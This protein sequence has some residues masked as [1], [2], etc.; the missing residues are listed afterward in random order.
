MTNRPANLPR[1]LVA[2]L[3][4]LTMV[5]G[6]APVSALAQDDW[7]QLVITLSWVDA[8]GNSSQ[9]DAQPVT[10][11]TDQSFWAQV[12]AD[13][14]LGALTITAAHPNHGY[15]F[16]I[17]DEDGSLN[18]YDTG[19]EMVTDNR[20]MIRAFEGDALVDIY[21]LY[22]STQIMPQEP[23]FTPAQA[24]VSVIWKD[25]AGNILLQDNP[26][27]TQGA[28]QT[29][30]ANEF[31]GYTF[32]GS[33]A[34]VTVSVDGNGTPSRNPVEFLYRADPKSAQ[35][36]VVWKDENGNVLAED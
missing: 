22:V 23:V 31:A 4:T 19:S 3:L 1:R 5:L 30:Y 17:G 27:I 10:W 11:S 28:D 6:L 13:A 26:T 15:S 21:Y 16:L 20:I 24:T 2:L 14:P 32:I 9:L 34:S 36:Q 33:E 25:E 18:I 12:T 7:Q 29:F 35:I 8:N